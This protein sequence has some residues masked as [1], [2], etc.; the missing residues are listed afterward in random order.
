MIRPAGFFLALA[1]GQAAGEPVQVVVMDPLALPLSCSCVEGVGQ[2]R[3]DQLAA[4]LEQATGR[5]F[6]LTFEESLDL[7]LR[8]IRSKPDFI[9]GKDA[10]VRFDAK[11][12]E[13]PVTPLADLTDRAGRTTQRGVFLVRTG[14]PAK[15]LADLSGRA[16][17]LGPAEEAETHQAAKAMLQKARLAKP[18]RLDSAGAIDSGVLALSDG[19][20]DAA[21]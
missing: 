4:H 20:V 15:R 12:L 7:A 10:M 16:V 13:L 8:R 21:V 5:R 19:E 9:I 3:Y 11:R 14:D 17:M 6:K 18:P 2:R 1:L